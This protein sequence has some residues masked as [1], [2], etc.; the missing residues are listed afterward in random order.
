MHTTVVTLAEM[1]AETVAWV[2]VVAVSML[3][4]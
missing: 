4:S 1:R 2:W 3:D